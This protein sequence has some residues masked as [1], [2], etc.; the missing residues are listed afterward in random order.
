MVKCL[1]GPRCFS[2]CFWVC[3]RCALPLQC[4]CDS[5]GVFVIVTTPSRIAQFLYDQAM[6]LAAEQYGW[7]ILFAAL[8]I[9]SFPPLIG[10]TT[11]IT[12]CGFAFGMKGFYIAASGSLV[13]SALVFALLRSFFSSKLS[14][15][16]KSNEKWQ[17][18]EEVV[19][20]KGLPLMILIR[21]SPFPPWV[22]S[23]A[24]FAS[25]EPVK[26]WQFVVATLFIF[27]RI[28]LHVF[29]GSRIAVLS[30]G[31]QRE[32]MD[33]HAR[34]VNAFLAIGGVILA[35]SASW[36]VYSLVRKHIRHPKSLYHNADV[37]AA[38]EAPDNFDE[39]APFLSY[40]DTL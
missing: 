39:Q 26:L 20:A 17:A 18:L 24:L 30:D 27:P 4:P 40:G 34:I 36:V 6:K 35:V 19:R 2:M 9:I 28:L 29:I 16:S 3:P 37:L 15:W 33:S 7:I 5:A 25:I 12:L 8:V 11:I 31:N 10:N 1:S 22:Y 32:H 21:V 14:Q 13:G 38:T 23:N